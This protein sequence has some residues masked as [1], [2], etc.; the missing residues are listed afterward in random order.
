MVK[1][2]HVPKQ[3]KYPFSVF[4][5]RTKHWGKYNGQIYLEGFE[6]QCDWYWSGGGIFSGSMWTHFDGCFLEVPDIRGHHLG[7]FITPWSQKIE[8]AV[9]LS[10]GCSVWEDITTF[11]DDVPEYLTGSNW[12]R[13]KDLYK[14]FYRLRHAAEVFQ[15][16]GHCS[17]TGRTPEEIVPVMANTINIHIE[18]VIIPEI[19]KRVTP[20]KESK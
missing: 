13:I 5:G 15:Y 2:N 10:N 3:K 18:T 7:N 17:S 19:I 11:L 20:P 8:G 16:G 1:E 14:Q 4:L 12:W 6:W 9:I